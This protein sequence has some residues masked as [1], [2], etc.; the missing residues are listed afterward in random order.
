LEQ[1]RSVKEVALEK[2][3]LKPEELERILDPKRLLN[4][5]R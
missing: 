4:E 5:K 2:G 1:G 3:L